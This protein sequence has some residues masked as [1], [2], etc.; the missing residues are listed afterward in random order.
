MGGDFNIPNSLWGS[1]MRDISAAV[2]DSAGAGIYS[3]LEQL[4]VGD[5]FHL[6]SKP[7][8][9]LSSFALRRPSE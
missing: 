5:L 6:G 2:M 1:Q 9:N 4:S 3:L 7:N 8:V